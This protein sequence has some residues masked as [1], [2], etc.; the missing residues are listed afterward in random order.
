M[1]PGYINLYPCSYNHILPASVV[2][3]ITTLG[4]IQFTRRQEYNY[5]NHILY[6][7]WASQK[8]NYS[9]HNE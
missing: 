6:T 8:E 2:K 7:F 1:I 3:N 5:Y 4:V 9:A